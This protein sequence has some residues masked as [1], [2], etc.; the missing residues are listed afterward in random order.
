MA[1]Y[2]NTNPDTVLFNDQA[3]SKTVVLGTNGTVQV[4][5]LLD[6]AESELVVS[7]VMAISDT[8]GERNTDV[9]NVF[10][11]GLSFAARSAISYRALEFPG[12]LGWYLPSR[13]QMDSVVANNAQLG[14][15]PLSAA[16]YWTSTEDSTA[17]GVRAWSISSTGTQTS[18][19]KG[20][21]YNVR[22]I[23]EIRYSETL[24]PFL[25]GQD[26]SYGIVYEIDTLNKV[27]Y[28]VSKVDVAAVIWGTG[29]VVS[30]ANFASSITITV[31]ANATPSGRSGAITLTLQQ[32][33]DISSVI[34]I[35]QTE[36]AIVP[37][38]VTD[39][40]VP[41]VS[42]SDTVL[43]SDVISNMMVGSINEQNYDFGMPQWEAVLLGKRLIQEM[44]YNG[45]NEVRF[46]EVRITE[47]NKVIPPIDFV[48]YISVSLPT[49]EGYLI[50]LF[51]NNEL[52]ISFQFVLDSDG[53]IVTD[54]EGY[55]IKTQGSRRDP[56]TLTLGNP[57]PRYDG[58]ACNRSRIY[59]YRGLPGITGG[60]RS[61]SGTYHY[62]RDAGEFLLDGVAEEFETVVIAYISDPILAERN[63]AR[64]SIQ[65]FY[66]NAL[67]NGIYYNYI[68]KMRTVPQSE[69]ARARH[70]YY[71]EFRIAKRRARIKPKE[72][73][74]KLAS[75]IGFN[76]TL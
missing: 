33:A 67:E 25:V 32:D 29:T 59:R 12:I 57:T 72:I 13:N 68:K 28:I 49:E 4:E 40:N 2:I 19:S 20:T 1:F 74:Q 39:E 64:I 35:S 52:N 50:P 14:L 53:N 60:Q 51:Y 7:N 44:G 34:A 24:P 56:E 54:D 38:E 58:D 47:A 63:P 11:T 30:N 27:I 31:K 76:K 69:K 16:N 10:E 18:T 22:P 55:P 61:F 23:R 41:I 36:G 6:W 9:I 71:N 62:D 43:L 70:E 48:D 17:N 75:D 37:I 73:I 5:E 46:Y 26:L 65:K 45:V 66:Q 3:G 8:D 21:L 42:A 15:F